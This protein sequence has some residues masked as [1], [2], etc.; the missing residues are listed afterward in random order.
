MSFVRRLLRPWCSTDEE[1]QKVD[2][3]RDESC[4]DGLGAAVEGPTFR[5]Q[6]IDFDEDAGLPVG[7]R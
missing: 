7:L 5:C 6:S 2:Q 3:Y 1:W 4:G